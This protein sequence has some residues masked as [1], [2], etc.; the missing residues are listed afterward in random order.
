MLQSGSR[1]WA[2]ENDPHARPLYAIQSL[3]SEPEI[4]RP[5]VL[6]VGNEVERR[7]PELLVLCEHVL[8]LPCTV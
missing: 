1:L 5:I 3:V 7:H 2:L 8:C 4:N 6:V